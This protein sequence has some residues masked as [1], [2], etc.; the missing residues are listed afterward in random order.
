MEILR[1][2]EP[3]FSI[4]DDVERVSSLRT[5]VSVLH[6]RVDESPLFDDR[7]HDE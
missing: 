6:T 1:I 4:T 2:S 3:D 7:Q 5:T